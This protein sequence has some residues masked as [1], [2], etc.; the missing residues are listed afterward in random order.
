MS[1][2]NKT[3]SLAIGETTKLTNSGQATSTGTLL[4]TVPPRPGGGE[5]SAIF[6]AVGTLTGLTSTLQAD[7]SGAGGTNLVTYIASLL[8]AA[9]SI[10]AVPASGST[11]LVAGV[12]YAINITALTGGPADFY[13]TLN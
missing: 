6:Q 3:V 4:F 2:L 9:T 5:H 1:Q 13:V 7:A 10:I 11:P 12:T 8:A